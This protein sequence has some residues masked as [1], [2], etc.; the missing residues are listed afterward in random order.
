MIDAA[1]LSE[2]LKYVHWDR[3]DWFPALVGEGATDAH[4][5]LVYAD[6]LEDHG[7]EPA[8]ADRVRKEANKSLAMAG[9]T[10]PPVRMGDDATEHEF[11]RQAVRTGHPSA[12][13]RAMVGGRVTPDQP[14]GENDHP[15]LTDLLLRSAH[16]SDHDVG[17]FLADPDPEPKNGHPHLNRLN[18]HRFR[19]QGLFAKQVGG[20]VYLLD[21]ED[22]EEDDRKRRRSYGAPEI[23]FHAPANDPEEVSALIE[24]A[25]QI[26][27]QREAARAGMGPAHIGAVSFGS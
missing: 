7:G 9:R 12:V 22:L 19:E 25:D 8:L 16:P 24:H 23:R 15:Q 26:R 13:V 11:V 5:Q 14:H 1:R 18:T 4:R 6:W 17:V 10:S 3:K 20:T 27:T 2:V 21:N